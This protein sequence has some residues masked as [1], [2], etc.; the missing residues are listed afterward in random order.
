VSGNAVE[1]LQRENE[2]LRAELEALRPRANRVAE[3]ENQVLAEQVAWFKRYFMHRKAD[4]VEDSG[5]QRLPFNKAELLSEAP[6]A[7]SQEVAA[8]SRKKAV[9]RPLPKD[10][11]RVQ[12]IVD[13]SEE[14]KTCGCG[15]ALSRIGEEKSEKLDI[16]PPRLRVIEQIRPKYACRQ[17]EGT[18]DEE[19]PAVRIA[20]VPQ[21][22]IPKGIATPGLVAYIVTGK[23][24]DS[25]PL[26]RQEKQFAR[27]G[28]DLSRRTMAD[29]MISAAGACEPVREAAARHLR[30]G[31]SVLIDETP[32]QVMKEPG[33]ANT[34]DSYAWVAIGGESEHPVALCRYEP[35]RSGNVV[36]EILDGFEGYAQSDGFGD[37]D[38]SIASLAKVIHVG[39][40]AHMRRKFTDAANILRIPRN[41]AEGPSGTG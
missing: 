6:Q 27:M 30:C 14:E 10:M 35:T 40:L 20:P 15:H 11:P 7:E 28:V 18:G 37:Y 3:L 19:H 32:V 38:W 9:R 12:Q 22:L 29:W 2:T 13:I 23:F 16:V 31:P 21:S 8:H 17:C 25:L 41:A 4:V 36:L 1:Q 33:R 39:C 24:E 5:Q 34:Q 26:Y